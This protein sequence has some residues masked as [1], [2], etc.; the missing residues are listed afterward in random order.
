MRKTATPNPDERC[1]A[2]LEE[3]ALIRRLGG[4]GFFDRSPLTR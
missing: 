4:A 3:V 1:Q 2:R